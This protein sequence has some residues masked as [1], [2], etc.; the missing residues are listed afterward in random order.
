VGSGEPCK[1]LGISVTLIFNYHAVNYI[2]NNLIEPLPAVKIAIADDHELF[3]NGVCDIINSFRNC[4]VIMQASDGKDLIDQLSIAEVLPDVC[5]IDINM[6][7]LNGYDTLVELKKK[8]SSLKVITLTMHTE[9]FVLQ[10]LVQLGADGYIIKNISPSFLETAIRSVIKNGF[11]FYSPEKNEVVNKTEIKVAPAINA[12]EM[13]F[14]KLCGR[15]LSYEEIATIMNVSPRTINSYQYT[16]TNKLKVKNR[17]GLAM[18]A[19][20]IG[21]V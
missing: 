11:Y 21:L 2:H 3:R 13:E 20:D 19:K 16:L 5:I 15:Q 18:F 1:V 6:P 9:K 14:L 10:K 7:V 17:F 8:F 12:G 4:R